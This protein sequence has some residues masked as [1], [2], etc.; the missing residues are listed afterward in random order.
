[1]EEETHGRAVLLVVALEVVGEEIVELLGVD[2]VGARVDH[3]AA[4]RL[5]VRFG[6]LA[7]VHLVHD[8]L[9]D[10]RRTSRALLLV[11]VAGVRHAVGQ[12]V[13]PQRRVRQRCRDRR[14]VHEE[15]VGRHVELV[16]TADAQQRS[17]HAVHLRARDVGE[18][19]DH[20]SSAVHLLGPVVGR[21]VLPVSLRVV[22][23]AQNRKKDECL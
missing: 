9:P 10:G 16:V 23:P 2:D 13:R 17:A 15:L 5:L 12:R 3:G 22:V 18:L 1:M 8:H 6:V 21:G 19:L 4:E 7:T 14:V 20:Q 11:A